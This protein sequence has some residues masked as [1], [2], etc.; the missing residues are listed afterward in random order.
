M[1]NQI[2]EI[3]KDKKKLR[4]LGFVIIDTEKILKDLLNCGFSL[5]YFLYTQDTENLIK[6]YNIKENLLKVKPSLINKL[7]SVENNRGFIAVF[8]IP[9][10]NKL[11]AENEKQLILFDTIQD[12]TNV[13]AMIRT[14]LAFGFDSYLFLDSVYIFNDKTIRASAGTCFMVK[15]LDVIL[16]D[17]KKLKNKKY[18]I[19]ITDN[20]K[21]E[22]IKDIMKYF[23]DKFI[24]VFGNEGS[25]I[26]DEIKTISD[27][28]VNIRYPNKK[29]ES[30]NV[31][32]A[33]SILFYEIYNIIK[34]FKK[35]F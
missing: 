17:I 8:Q 1:K 33:A 18:R 32:N 25:G 9:Q 16:D 21:G 2:T 29:V 3:L 7:S 4:Q 23:E 10:D 30:L 5:K 31:A 26:R 15:Y 34:I 20:E 6:K 28:S 27:I 11:I 12:P 35:I 24:L 13:G 14:G 19:I 22:D